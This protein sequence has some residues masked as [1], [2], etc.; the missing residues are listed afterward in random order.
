MGTR[1]R[2]EPAEK[3]VTMKFLIV[4]ACF[5]AVGCAECCS[6]KEPSLYGSPEAFKLRGAGYQS[7]YGTQAY[8]NGDYHTKPYQQEHYG[9]TYSQPQSNYGT[10]AYGNGDYHTKPYQ[11]EHYGTTYSQSQSYG[12]ADY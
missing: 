8:G 11:Q 4:L 5:L 10:Q 7:T 9:T 6:S 3:R 1:F 12:G 2:I